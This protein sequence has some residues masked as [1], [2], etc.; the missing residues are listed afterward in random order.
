MHMGLTL[1]CSGL[2][3]LV[4]VRSCVYNAQL[5][6]L[7]KGGEAPS[8]TGGGDGDE[9]DGKDDDEIKI[10]E[11]E[12]AGAQGMRDDRAPAQG[13]GA[14]A[15]V[16]PRSYSLST[17]GHAYPCTHRTCSRS[18]RPPQTQKIH[19]STP[20]HPRPLPPPLPPSP[21]FGT[22]KKRLRT[23][24]GGSTGSVRNLRI[25]EDI[26][27]YLLNLDP[28]SAYYD[29]K[30]RSAVLRC[31][32]VRA[33][34]ACKLH[35]EPPGAGRAGQGTHARK[36]PPPRLC[37]C[38][39]GTPVCGKPPCLPPKPAPRPPCSCWCRCCCP[40]QVHA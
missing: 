25:R 32:A 30:S 21:A 13:G 4:C 15:E 12:E 2:A 8:G 20:H 18:L 7:H 36:Y 16:P 38:P 22:V 26:A 34:R 3:V 39:H 31:A 28:S 29:P 17:A 6:Q 23:A 9:E 11:E 1:L 19:L 5:A 37:S 33:G 14:A 40:W 27:K 35:A 24:G 10:N